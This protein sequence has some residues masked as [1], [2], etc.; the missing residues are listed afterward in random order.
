MHSQNSSVSLFKW[1]LKPPLQ[2]SFKSYKNHMKFRFH[3][4]CDSSDLKRASGFNL[5]GLKL[6][7]DSQSELGFFIWLHFSFRLFE[8]SL[9][10]STS[11]TIIKKALMKMPNNI[12][13]RLDLWRH[14]HRVANYW[15]L[16]SCLGSTKGF[17]RDYQMWWLRKQFINMFFPSPA[18]QSKATKS[19]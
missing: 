5:D 11:L 16:A 10:Q 18:N 12:L 8:K 9:H 15:S 14:K 2:S 3:V 4:I 19:F 17:K 6:N 13:F 7:F 1:H